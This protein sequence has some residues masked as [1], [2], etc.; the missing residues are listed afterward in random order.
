[1]ENNEEDWNPMEM[2]EK[3]KCDYLDEIYNNNKNINNKAMIKNNKQLI[4]DWDDLYMTFNKEF[5]VDVFEKYCADEYPLIYLLDK[6]KDDIN[7]FENIVDFFYGHY[8]CLWH[9]NVT[10]ETEEVEYESPEYEEG[11]RE[12]RLLIMSLANYYKSRRI[13]ELLNK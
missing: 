1:M 9:N 12:H 10:G 6:M 2:W 5:D 13:E 7:G 8:S 11:L 4:T 3:E